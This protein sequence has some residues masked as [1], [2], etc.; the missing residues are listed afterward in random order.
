MGAPDSNDA[1]KRL[2]GNSIRPGSSAHERAVNPLEQ[3]LGFL[4]PT[5]RS[6][7]EPA[8]PVE[9]IA[10]DALSFEIHQPQIVLRSRM[11]RVRGTPIA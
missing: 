11:P 2:R 3:L 8:E 4:V 6:L 9:R 10:R 5:I 1:L 7:G